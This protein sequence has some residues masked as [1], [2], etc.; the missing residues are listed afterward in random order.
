MPTPQ[1]CPTSHLAARSIISEVG[2][3]GGNSAV[4]GQKVWGSRLEGHTFKV[5]L[6]HGNPQF[7]EIGEDHSNHA[8]RVQVLGR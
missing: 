5:T 1:L 8:L 4:S 3:K 6:N 2:S 7:I